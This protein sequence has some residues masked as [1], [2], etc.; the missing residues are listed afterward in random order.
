MAIA[1]MVTIPRDKA[2]IFAKAVL[3]ARVCACA[4]I[5]DNVSSFFWWEGKI[6]EAHEAL[7]IMKTKD[8]LFPQLKSV[9][10]RNHPYQVPEIIAFKIEQINEEYLEWINKE[11]CA[12]PDSD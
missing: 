5:V 10:K 8:E 6:D 7:I 9:V 12:K 1:V 11:A 2:N 4:N 3:E